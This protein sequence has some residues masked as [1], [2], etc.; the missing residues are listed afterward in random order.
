MFQ[1][2][3]LNVQKMSNSS[4]AVNG[5]Q[6]QRNKPLKENATRQSGSDPQTFLHLASFNIGDSCEEQGDQ[7]GV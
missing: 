3:R 6:V 2:H 1:K 5:P 4:N 7:S